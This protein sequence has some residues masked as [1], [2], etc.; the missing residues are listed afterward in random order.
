MSVDETWQTGLGPCLSRAARRTVVLHWV[1][2]L[3]KR[4]TERD[5]VPISQDTR[6]VFTDLL[7]IDLQLEISP[8]NEAQMK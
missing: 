7:C 6:M 5:L 4:R 8:E 3:C 2:W 1:V